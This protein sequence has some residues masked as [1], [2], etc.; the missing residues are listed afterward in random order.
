MSLKVLIN[1]INKR[2]SVE[3]GIGKFIDRAVKKSALVMEKNIK[4]VS[5]SAFVWRTGNLGRS[6]SANKN[7]LGFGKA[8]VSINPI[9]EESDVNYGIHLEYGTKYIAPRAF[10]RRGAAN[11]EDKIKDIF[12]DEAKSMK[13]KQLGVK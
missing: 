11:S 5:R 2:S 13:D 3:D 8:E 7:D 10:I 4:D 9:S 12:R 6:I 1:F